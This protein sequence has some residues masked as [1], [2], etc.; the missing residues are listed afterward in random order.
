LGLSGTLGG[1]IFVLVGVAAEQAGPGVLLAFVLAFGAAFLIAL[2]YAELAGRFPQAGGSY[3]ATRATLGSEWGFLMGWGYWGGWVFASGFVTIGF[4]GYLHLLTGL[5]PVAGAVALIVTITALNLT[6]VRLVGRIQTGVIVLGVGAL[7][8]FAVLGL[9]ATVAHAARFV[10]LLPRGLT[11]VAAATPPAFLAL[12]GFDTVATAGEEVIRPSRTLP[13]AILLTLLIAVGLYLLVTVV[14]IG[15]LP[16]EML[17]TS[18]VPLAEAAVTFLGPIGGSLIAVAALLTTAATANAALVVGSRLVFALARDGL[19]PRGVGRTRAGSG[20]PWAGV[21]LTGAALVAVAAAGSFAVAAAVGGFLYALHFSF[22][23]IGL[24]RLR[25]QSGPP[26]VFR[27]PAP[28]L[29]LPLALVACVLLLG[30]SGR[31]GVIGGSGWLL[32]GLLARQLSR[33]LKADGR[34][35]VSGASLGGDAARWA[36][37]MY[38]FF[39]RIVP[40]PSVTRGV[41]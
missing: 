20:T 19:L 33:A 16:V 35:L 23:L 1:G 31:V 27:S 28:R 4:G 24:V 39:V 26:P 14:A 30:T 22:P 15:A 8:A 29:V 2:P 12:N 3:A 41:K 32:A 9:P 18:S 10:P 7:I 25:R 17:G 21:L 6:N 5:S 34:G 40:V 37:Q 13:R 36:D 38:A 11:G